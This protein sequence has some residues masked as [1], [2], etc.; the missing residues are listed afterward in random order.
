MAITHIL[1]SDYKILESYIHFLNF[2][3]IITPN[4]SRFREALLENFLQI[5]R[6]TDRQA[7]RRTDGRLDK[8]TDRRTDRQ[9]D[10]QTDRHRQTHG[11]TDRETDR[12]ADR[13]TDK[14]TDPIIDNPHEWMRH[15]VQIEDK[16]SYIHFLHFRKILSVQIFRKFTEAITQNFP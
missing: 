4:F 3:K 2:L 1:H 9:T 16:K 6:P 12:Q 5:S 10:K 13:P 7:D 8:Q 14:P 15:D 11:Q